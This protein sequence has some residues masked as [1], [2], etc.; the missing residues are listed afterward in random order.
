MDKVVT[1]LDNTEDV[2]IKDQIDDLDTQVRRAPTKEACKTLIASARA[3]IKKGVYLKD[4]SSLKQ[5]YN[6]KYSLTSVERSKILLK[7]ADY[8]KK[9]I[10]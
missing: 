1:Q 7:V 8:Y 5:C 2:Y 9:N 6:S 3:G 4:L 10:V